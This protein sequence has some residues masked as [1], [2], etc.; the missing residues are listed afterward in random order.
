MAD[1]IITD[2][3]TT[4]TV[5]SLTN[6]KPGT[7]VGA[8]RESSSTEQKIDDEALNRMNTGYAT[9]DDLLR[10]RWEPS[11]MKLDKEQKRKALMDM[12]WQFFQ[13]K[14]KPAEQDK[15][16]NQIYGELTEQTWFERQQAKLSPYVH[17]AMTAAGDIAGTAA[18]GY[19]TGGLAP[20]AT[21]AGRIG[22]GALKY[23]SRIAGSLGGSSLGELGAQMG[24]GEDINLR[25]ALKQGAISGATEGV[26]GGIGLGARGAGSLLSKTTMA[27]SAIEKKAR[28]EL[29]Q[30]LTR[31]AQEAL[32]DY[33]LPRISSKS[34]AG[35]EVTEEFAK[36]LDYASTF[37]EYNKLLKSD[38]I[39]DTIQMPQTA[40]VIKEIVET[41]KSKTPEKIADK[42]AMSRGLGIKNIEYKNI[43][44][45]LTNTNLNAVDRDEAKW[46]LDQVWKEGKAKTTFKGLAPKQE[47]AKIKL[48]EAIL[49]DL[50]NAV[51]GIWDLKTAADKYYA[52]AT[53]FLNSNRIAKQWMKKNKAGFIRAEDR[54]TEFVDELF[55]T[56]SVDDLMDFRKLIRETPDGKEAWDALKYHWIE[57][58]Y[59]KNMSMDKY[60][61]EMKIYPAMLANDLMK[62]RPMIEK[63]MPE[64][65][66][67]LNKE[68]DRYIEATPL[69]MRQRLE[70]EGFWS[71]QRIAAPTMAGVFSVYAVPIAE[72]AGGLSA[73]AVT[74]PP[75][76][77]LLKAGKTLMDI[78]AKSAVRIPQYYEQRAKEANR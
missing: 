47:A 45:Q 26:L 9:G 24:L 73:L 40:S 62:K 22:L 14:D 75:I 3:Q 42:T 54:P 59:T 25:E 48:K 33:G 57:G 34:I 44:N 10:L 13:L 21:T 74:K 1:S 43:L 49:Y 46:L 15:I 38:W 7:T 35:L 5:P 60:S 53:E 63:L 12:S 58:L 29:V 70:R 37:K 32:V 67:K 56:E 78:G 16:I 52:E 69:F 77:K 11:F 68:I 66:P 30:K 71:V 61:G 50:D 41:V 8:V 72:I 18:A 23:G 55:K 20:A 17:P 4:P 19:L 76:G 36:K 51:P 31:D 64:V 27:G 39:G 6:L 28:D 65:V 2:D